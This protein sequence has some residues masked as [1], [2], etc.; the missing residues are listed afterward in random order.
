[1]IMALIN[2]IN[3]TF[4]PRTWSVLLQLT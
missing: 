4:W 3:L 1:M 2:D